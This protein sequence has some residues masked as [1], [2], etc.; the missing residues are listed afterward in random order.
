MTACAVG[1]IVVFTLVQLSYIF[2][3]QSQWCYTS[4]FAIAMSSI[5]DV[6]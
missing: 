4:S 5:L 3:L 6:E 2:R 1:L